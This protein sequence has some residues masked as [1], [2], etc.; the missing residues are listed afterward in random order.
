M[1]VNRN[2]EFG[3]KLSQSWREKKKREGLRIRLSI[4]DFTWSI[5]VVNS[6]QYFDCD[7]CQESVKNCPR[8][9]EKKRKREENLQ[10]ALI[11]L[12]PT[13]LPDLMPLIRIDIK[14]YFTK[15]SVRSY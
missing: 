14:K 9:G 3:S 4:R 10:V 8:V 13:Q 6:G 2:C 1:I 11:C 5:L 15:Q 12:R 7:Y